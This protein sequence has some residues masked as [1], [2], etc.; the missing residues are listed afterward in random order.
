[1]RE[2]G[3]VVVLLRLFVDVKEVRSLLLITTM[4]PAV[5]SDDE[6]ADTQ[7]TGEYAASNFCQRIETHIASIQL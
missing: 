3:V 5:Q 6:Y 4:Y 2:S 7:E 1:M